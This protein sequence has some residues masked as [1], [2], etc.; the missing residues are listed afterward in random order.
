MTY[1]FRAEIKR[2]DK[3][4]CGGDKWVEHESGRGIEKTASP[5]MRDCYQ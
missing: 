3:S 5:N 4:S 2:I 1:K